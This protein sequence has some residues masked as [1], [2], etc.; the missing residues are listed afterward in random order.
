MAYMCLNTLQIL[1]PQAIHGLKIKTRLFYICKAEQTL[2]MRNFSV[3]FP[4]KFSKILDVSCR[5][6]TRIGLGLFS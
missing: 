5:I 2:K 4:L 6:L 1:K 3:C